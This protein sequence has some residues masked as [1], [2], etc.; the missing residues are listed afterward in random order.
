M[1][2][3]VIVALAAVVRRDAA[4]G[5]A[6]A[7][8]V[9]HAPAAASSNDDA[10]AQV[11]HPEQEEAAAHGDAAHEQVEHPEHE[12]AAA[13][14]EGEAHEGESLWRTIARLLNFAILA[15]GLAYLLKTP[16]ANYL[17][18]RAEQISRDLVEA[19]QLR[20]T[21]GEQIAQINEQLRAL[22]GEL[23][24]LKARGA[25]EIAAEETRIR[26]AAE[27]ARARLLE[28]TRREVDQRV[29]VA[30]QE[31]L[32]EAADLAVG[33]AAE[34]I[35]RDLTPEGHLRLVDRYAEQVQQTG[36]GRE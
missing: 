13:H 21:A 17:K 33:A 25:D 5:V 35:E 3:C 11:E 32:R 29:R 19:E 9:P 1:L 30:R 16:L 14:G 28:Q 10:D 6:V 4:S 20:A 18:R 26:Q 2:A 8:E 15:V 27:A 31:L 24:V 7:Q 34:R 12:D 36:S 22:P 23:E